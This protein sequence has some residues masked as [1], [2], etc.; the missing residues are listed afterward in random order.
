MDLC[1]MELQEEMW[2]EHKQMYT[3]M[4]DLLWHL[5]SSASAL[6]Q[7][8]APAH[9]QEDKSFAPVIAGELSLHYQIP[10]S[11]NQKKVLTS[12]NQQSI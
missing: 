11:G 3:V 9:L 4:S 12:R 2:V 5:A 8:L 1:L 10:I 6:S 7:N